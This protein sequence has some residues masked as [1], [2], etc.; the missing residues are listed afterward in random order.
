MDTPRIYLQVGAQ[1]VCSRELVALV[2]CMIALVDCM[3]VD[4][5]NK[6]CSFGKDS[7]GR[8]IFVGACHIA[9]G[10]QDYNYID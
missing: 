8:G 5:K 1:P 4:C 6:A 9:F 7:L 10:Q 2:D 3:M